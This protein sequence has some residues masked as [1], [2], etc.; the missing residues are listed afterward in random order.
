MNAFAFFNNN[1]Y[2]NPWG[3]EDN[4]IFGF[5]PYEFTDPEFYST[6]MENFFDEFTGNDYGY[7]NYYNRG[8]N[9]YYHPYNR[10]YTPY[11]N[12]YNR[13]YMPNM[14]VPR[15]YYNP[16]MPPMNSPYGNPYGNV[17]QVPASTTK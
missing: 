1:D 13:G 16:Y 7:G 12:P 3:V 6:E 8:Y 14:N 17:N 2:N 5:N 11:Y 15:N 4:G 10:G 9:P